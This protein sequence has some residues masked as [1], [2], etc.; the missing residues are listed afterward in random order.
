MKNTVW[1]TEE[2][3]LTSELE[4]VPAFGAKDVG[5]DRSMIGAYGQDDRVC[6][7]TSFTALFDVQNPE[8][9]SICVLTDKEEIGQRGQYRSRIRVT[10]RLHGRSLLPEF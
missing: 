4:L 3:F 10:G 9:T 5:F 6:A 7:Y 8:Y 1:G 2:D